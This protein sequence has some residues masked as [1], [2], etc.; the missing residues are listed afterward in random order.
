M[1]VVEPAARV[2]A[3][4]RQGEGHRGR[5]VH[6]RPEPHRPA[7]REV[8]LRRPHARAHRLDRHDAARGRCRASSPSS[9]TRTSPMCSTATRPRTAGCSRARRCA[10][11]RTSSPPSP[12]G[13]RRSPPRR[14]PRS[15]S[16][17]SRFRRSAT[18]RRQRPRARRLI[19]EDWETY[20]ADEELGLKGNVLGFSTI[21]KGDADA[22]DRGRRRRRR[23]EGPLRDRIVAG[24]A[25]RAAGDPRR[26]ARRPGDRLEL[27]AGSLRRA[28]RRRARPPA[29]RGAR[30]D[31]RPV[32][33]RRLRLQVRLPLRG[34]RGRARARGRPAGE[35]R[36]LARGG[37]RRA[38]PPP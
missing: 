19:H 24:R 1:S 38:R 36:L 21:V 27:D 16:S 8:P 17:T 14:R 33:R 11:R 20:E 15:R 30:A 4:G 23:R 10:S 5:A 2:P 32:A 22:G 29:P 37:V 35:A 7:A 18:S 13:R 12:R 28:G 9:R 31:R 6:G 26:V 34:P 3:P 25:D